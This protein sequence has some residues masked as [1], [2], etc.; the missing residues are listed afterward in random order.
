MG[1]IM[2]IVCINLA[3]VSVV[4][5]FG[6]FKPSSA[7]AVNHLHCSK[8]PTA[9][10]PTLCVSNQTSISDVMAHYMLDD[11]VTFNMTSQEPDA[12]EMFYNGSDANMTSQGP[13][14]PWIIHT[15]RDFRLATA[16]IAV[17]GLIGNTLAIFVLCH[18]RMWCS[19]AYLLVILAVYDDVIL[20][21]HIYKVFDNSKLTPGVKVLQT[22][23]FAPIK[24]TATTGTIYMTLMVTVERFVAVT[25]PLR[26]RIIFSL[27]AA[28]WIS[29][30]VLLGS[31]LYNLPHWFAYVYTY[32]ANTARGYPLSA[33]G[34][35]R[36]YSM[37]YKQYCQ[38]ALMYVL[39]WVTM[40]VL[41]VLLLRAVRSKRAFRETAGRSAGKKDLGARLTLPVMAVTFVFFFAY[42][43]L[44]IE[45]SLCYEFRCN[46]KLFIIFTLISEIAKVF[47]STAN[48][49]FY[50]F[51]GRRFRRTF[52]YMAMSWRH[53]LSR[54]VT[55]KSADFRFST[56]VDGNSVFKLENRTAL[57]DMSFRANSDT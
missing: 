55:S 9:L 31:L 20:V 43:F 28:R 52:F 32:E 12:E 1:Q 22:I 21:L 51:L 46:F 18:R 47:N 3:D 11:D 53:R 2:F 34:Q 50:C 57:N 24:W 36:A 23:A 5:V 41:N 30:C 4:Q 44:A 13:N 7:P 6:I 54:V 16:G 40:V 27:R 14:M 17:F 25:S 19:T 39:P 45:D 38:L 56:T 26:S 29:L 15:T 10:T 37:V 42:P 49:L 8:L 35:S 48:F 33:F